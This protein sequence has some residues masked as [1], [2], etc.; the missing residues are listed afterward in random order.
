[1]KS[2][3]GF[4][5]IIGIAYTINCSAQN[6][7]PVLNIGTIV[8]H[9]KAQVSSDGRYVLT[10]DSRVNSEGT[11][12]LWDTWIR[13]SIKSYKTFNG[14]V[15]LM[16]GDSTLLIC[17]DIWRVEIVHLFSK[18]VLATFDIGREINNLEVSDDGKYIACSVF[19]SIVDQ[20][21]L[22]FDLEKKSL[23][24]TWNVK[25]EIQLLKFKRNSPE[26]YVCLKLEY[27]NSESQP[28]AFKYFNCKTGYEYSLGSRTLL[29]LPLDISENGKYVISKDGNKS[30]TYVYS[31]E[32]GNL[33]FKNETVSNGFFLSSNDNA[34]IL[35]E[36][37][38]RDKYYGIYIPNDTRPLEDQRVYMS[39][40]DLKT[41]KVTSNE[42]FEL[43]YSS[44]KKPHLNRNGKYLII[45]ACYLFEMNSYVKL[46]EARHE[47]KSCDFNYDFSGNFITAVNHEGIWSLPV[48]SNNAP[49]EPTIYFNF[50]D[51]SV[52]YIFRKPQEKIFVSSDSRFYYLT[53]YVNGKL[54]LN[55]KNFETGIVIDQISFEKNYVFERLSP[56][57]K[58][59]LLTNYPERIFYDLEKKEVITKLKYSGFEIAYSP[60]GNFVV[61]NEA[62]KSL[63][64]IYNFNNG[65][66]E[67]FAL[68]KKMERVSF[69][70]ND[71]FAILKESKK[72]FIHIVNAQTRSLLVTHNL[73]VNQFNPLKVSND[74]NYFIANTTLYAIKSKEI[75]KSNI[76]LSDFAPDNKHA[77]LILENQFIIKFYDIKN[78]I[79]IS[80]DSILSKEIKFVPNSMFYASAGS[81]CIKL[82]NYENNTD[83]SLYLG[84]NNKDWILITNDGYWDSSEQ[85]S[86]LIS[87]VNDE[88]AW[89][90]DQFAIKNNRPDII[91]QRLGAGSSLIQH[92]AN[93]YLKR[94]RKSGLKEHELSKDYKLPITK[95]EGI[96]LKENFAQIKFSLSDDLSLSRYCIYIND[97]PLFG[98]NGKSITGKLA[99][100]TESV[101]LTP[102]LNKIEISCFNTKG[103]ESF[104]S[105]TFANYEGSCKKDL[106]L[107]AFGVSKYQ[108]P[109]YNLAYADK[110]ALDL[111]KVIASYKGKGFENVYTKVL[112]N[113]QVTPEAIKAAK[114]FV[115]NAKPDDTFILFIAGH[116]MH[117]KDAEATYYYLTSNA[118]IN[119]LKGT[120]ADFET[121]EDLLQGIPPRNKL[122][123]MDACESG[124]IDEE[125]Q[126]QM[127]ATATGV[128]ISSRGFKTISSQSTVNR[129]PS[130]KRSYLYQKDRYIYNDLVRRSGAI[131][132]SSSKGGELSYERSDIQ[133]GLF[134]YWVMKALTTKD[135]DKNN[136]GIV[137]T[138]ELREYVSVEVAKASGDLQHPTVDRDNIYQKF[139]FY[140][141]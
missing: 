124:E 42:P 66:F 45:D 17:S 128:G 103:V 49:D 22:I 131:V 133:N 28:F 139:G 62:D 55:K 130:T 23:K 18:G 82:K 72:D 9:E 1:M 14:I 41:G 37:F 63:V 123:L 26:V 138:D 105:I 5:S 71:E 74:A 39:V 97:I 44:Y 56:N 81:S 101:E 126:G 29:G 116:G 51:A 90:I 137:S 36:S 141:K 88:N 129:Q 80:S 134:T 100:I 58:I 132:F 119:N 79:F 3:R 27:S 53:K 93:M 30:F 15:A 65:L 111:S 34:Y 13:K 92:Y 76:S 10:C 2:L 99:S 54:S 60:M 108:N 24:W 95:I 50:K 68:K 48:V 136:D 12:L 25:N 20:Q 122:F 78:G 98:A 69:S 96:S 120:A 61:F 4:I 43:T 47:S 112:T 46:F 19:N 135:A 102:G 52:K 121:I 77:Y 110:D 67:N 115:K 89:N 104:R 59:A 117:D 86:E 94:L 57:G 70:Q 64:T 33:I 114:E 73:Q 38:V 75:I 35:H 125:D 127:I 113:E 106:Y 40:V 107:L 11:V 16:P 83:V 140:I 31:L 118:D 109:A 32:K 91:L 21:V 87:M 6:P 8:G 7:T 85:G 84:Y